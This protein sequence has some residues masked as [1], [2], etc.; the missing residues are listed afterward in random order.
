MG[1]SRMNVSVE[2]C[3]SELDI[4]SPLSGQ[5]TRLMPCSYAPRDF[6]VL[7]DTLERLSCA[8]WRWTYLVRKCALV[9]WSSSTHTWTG[10]TSGATPRLQGKP[11]VVATL[12]RVNG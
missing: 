3:I 10:I 11:L 9:P 8:G 7:I 6:N 4:G 1:L 2:L 12:Q 5:E